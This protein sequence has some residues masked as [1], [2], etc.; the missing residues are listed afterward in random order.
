[1]MWLRNSLRLVSLGSDAKE[2][3]KLAWIA[4]PRL[5]WLERRVYPTASSELAGLVALQFGNVGT[6][7]AQVLVV[8]SL[9]EVQQVLA[10]E[11]TPG[12][13]DFRA[14]AVG[15]DGSI[16]FSGQPA[17]MS[18]GIYRL[19]TTPGSF[20]LI[21]SKPADELAVDGVGDVVAMRFG[22]NSKGQSDL[23]QVTIS[24]IAPGTGDLETV[25]YQDTGSGGAYQ[26]V[27]ADLQ[28]HVY[29]AGQPGSGSVDGIYQVGATPNSLT[30]IKAEHADRL[31]TDSQ[32]NL[33]SM[34]F[35]HD[36]SGHDIG[37]AVISQITPA[38]AAETVLYSD[39]TT[40]DFYE[41]LAVESNG[42]IVFSG[43]PGPGMTDGIYRLNATTG[44]LDLLSAKHADQVAITGNDIL[45]MRFGQAA[46]GASAGQT[47]Q[48]VEVGSATPIETVISHD[49]TATNGAQQHVAVGADGTLV[50]SGQPAPG[51]GTGIYERAPGSSTFQLVST[52]PA[53]GLAIDAQ[54]DILA[55]RFGHDSHGNPLGA[56]IS[57]IAP[58]G[59]DVETVVYQDN[60]GAY[61]ALAVDQH[62]NIYFAGRPSATGSV[63]GIYQVGKTPASATL[64]KA[65]HEDRLAIDSEGDILA[66]RFGHDS[67]G[68]NIGGATISQIAPA[69]GQ[70]TVLYNDSTLGDYYQDLAVG[71]NDRVLF[72]GQPGK[73]MTDGVYALNANLGAL[74]LLSAKHADQLAVDSEGDL[75]AMRFGHAAYG[76]SAGQAA[77]LAESAPQPPI[78]TVLLHDALPVSGTYQ[79]VAVGPDGRTVISG[80][81]APGFSPGIYRL[82]AA[83]SSLQ[84][85]SNQAANELAIDSAG[86]ILAMRFG[87]D[88]Y[89]HV[90][91]AS[92]TEYSA[93][94]GAA[95]VIYN[96]PSTADKY[97]DLAVDPHGN[98]YIAGQ[99]GTSAADGVYK[100]VAGSSPTLVASG[101]ADRLAIDSDGDL[102]AM[103]FAHDSYGNNIGGATI[104][105]IAPSGGTPTVIYNDPSNGQNIYNDMAVG[106]N[107]QVLFSGHPAA[108]TTDG[109]YALDAT[110]GE[111]D[112][113]LAAHTDRL[114]SLGAGVVAE[115]GY[116]LTAT[117]GVLSTP[118][119]LATFSDPR[120][121]SPLADYS[122]Q[123]SWGDQTSSAGALTF[124]A[125][126]GVFTVTGSHTYSAAT[127]TQITVVIGRLGSANTTVT[128]AANVAPLPSTA[129]SGPDVLGTRSGSVVQFGDQTPFETL[130]AREA[131]QGA[132]DFRAL[133]TGSDGTVVF[134]AKP[135]G[136]ADGIYRLGTTPGS[137]T[138]VSS[139]PADKLA[140]DSHGDIL[141]M[142][143]GHDAYGHVA[144]ATISSIAPGTGDIETVIYQNAAG[145][146]QDLAVDQHGN[147]YFAGQPGTSATDGIY[148]VGSTP[149]SASL[150]KAE[151]TDRLAI[152]SEGDLLAMRFGQNS[153]GNNIGGAAISQIAPASGAE[154]VIYNDATT[155]ERYYQ[156]LA[157]DTNGRVLFSDN[158]GEIYRLSPATGTLDLV[159]NTQA[160]QIAVDAKGD[161]LAMRTDLVSGVGQLIELGPQTSVEPVLLRGEGTSSPVVAVASNGSVVVSGISEPGTGAGIYRLS[162]NGSLQLVSKQ[163][164]DKLAID[165]EGDILAMRFGHDAYGNDVGAAV[166]SIAPGG[167]DV[168]TL[169]YQDYGG[170]Y[171]DMAVDQHGN[172]YLAGQPSATG[173]TDGVYELGT[174][175]N[176]LTLVKA[177]HADALA[178]DAEGD[179]LAMRFGHDAYGDH[180]GG[181]IVSEIAPAT[182]AQ[183]VLYNDPVN[184]YEGMMAGPN[185]QIMLVGSPGGANGLYRLN[186][187]A[188]TLDLLS[189]A[190]VQSAAVD[191]EGNILTASGY[192]GG[193]AEVDEIT[194]KAPLE[195]VLLPGST[196]G[197]QDAV[198]APDGSLIVSGQPPG[199]SSPGIYQ[200]GNTPGNPKLI[201]STPAD[202]LAVDSE[203]D[204]FAVRFA[205]DAYGQN[206]GSVSIAEYNAAS[207]AETI[208]YNDSSTADK[209]Q[210]LAVDQHGNVY[211]AGQ[212]GATAADGVYKLV[213]GS[214]PSLV[215]SGHADRLA[216]DSE[217][218]LLAMQFGH[219]AYGH[220][221]GGTI[222]QISPAGGTPSVIYNDTTLGDFYNDIAVDT[223][224]QTLLSGTPGPGMTDGVYT[225]NTTSGQLSLV[226]PFDTGQIAALPAA[227]AATGGATIN[228]NVGA[229]TGN[230]T[231]AT[232]TDPAGPGPLAIY[233]ADVSWGD[234]SQPTTA[235]ISFDA[236]SGTFTVQGSHT[237][238]VLGDLPV[239]V[240]VHRAGSADANVGD[241]VDVSLP[242][243]SAGTLAMTE[244]TAASSSLATFSDPISGNYTAVINWGD[245][246][247]S[248][249]SVSS[250]ADGTQTVVGSHAYSEEG[251][252]TVTVTLTDPDGNTAQTQDTAVVADATINATASAVGA[253]EGSTFSG[254]LAT[255]SDADPNGTVGD[256]TATINWGDGTS[257]A[258][259][260]TAAASGGFAVTGAHL[261]AEEAQNL[262]IS[263]VIADVGGARSTSTGTANVADASLH[264]SAATVSVTSSGQ[265][266]NLLIATFTDD[267]GPEPAANYH[268]AIDWGDGSTTTGSI[269]LV[270]GVFQVTG[271]HQYAVGSGTFQVDVSVQ[272][273][274]GSTDA[275][276]EQATVQLTAHQ[277]YVSGVYEDVLARPPDPPG[278]A[279]WTQQ[280]D[281]GSLFSSIAAEIGHSAEYYANFVIKPDY[282]R[283]LGRAADAAGLQFWTN[284]MLG[285][286]TDQ[287]LEAGFIAS[288]EFYA[289]AGNT[290]AAWVT[291][292]YKLLLGRAPDQTGANYWNAQLASLET[293]E[294]AI[295]ARSQIALRIAE[296]QENNTNLINDD[297]FH[298]LGRAA[299]P[300]GLQYWLQQF[301]NGETNEDVIAGFTGS[302]EYYKDKTGVSP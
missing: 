170:S 11:A 194:P 133:A 268:A 248:A 50:I 241:Q 19:G 13:G 190:A 43:Q 121:P 62:G 151:H 175:S 207:G 212:P 10:Q 120:G 16:V 41:G 21:S 126:T 193:A 208:V 92:I 32:G 146:Y 56:T 178:V 217:G 42:Q 202:E 12:S 266:A 58:G 180:T 287:Q 142:R 188:G 272:D 145:A 163:P 275:L 274:G 14:L 91:G 74:D 55:M 282:S 9:E 262:P 218:D 132:G 186:A 240:T 36:S 257:S 221:A 237:Y 150:I 159:G 128:S 231:L 229:T 226:S 54:D 134:S 116:I 192:A 158:S 20:Q 139:Q 108:G 103:R 48:L 291:A 271:S 27:A 3:R 122:A 256:Y 254:T 24:S 100:L 242:S 73:G 5:E 77:Q 200:L 236:T 277:L 179:I 46:Y 182:G 52:T 70:E 209:Y 112:L 172:I 23:S 104:S 106:A 251:T 31:A 171:Q 206:A 234:Q 35:G 84:V 140:I 155:G 205:H 174:K 203:G 117:P 136:M 173:S 53:D 300:Q 45:A 60:G 75:L 247:T 165:S 232:F 261:Y 264:L 302:P 184:Y 111:I 210:D 80:E 135:A 298:Y 1:M 177:G 143:L 109:V 279:F 61:Q 195:T 129:Q 228:A 49:A 152:D 30:L 29:V 123:I 246:A 7:V 181:A 127:Q 161:I 164:A 17:G 270:N 223:A 197:Y 213:P 28:G 124:D 156:G 292:V 82:G 97:Q 40:G 169:L 141:A 249:G 87:H 263:V 168:E 166:A 176:G 115:G 15:P 38:T 299:D 88:A 160:D 78:E 273:D 95:T 290:D 144:G 258:G 294:T 243:S 65:E 296:S 267:G 278:L 162:S 196:S 204:I 96:D 198:A 239:T 222:S 244:G 94:S 201:S 39:T 301:A 57:S 227:I 26:D 137:F 66:M 90:G 37:G 187:A 79:D 250:S 265:A 8:P 260:V 276:T 191:A 286:L 130:L 280:L 157:V 64:I 216:V 183:T 230:Q 22:T 18:D 59:G 189:T 98:V 105:E 285:G 119:T 253:T 68:H 34:H 86:D 295:Q 211:L 238:T 283:L 99:P 167:G 153:Y 51:L 214:S 148:Q 138:L 118:Q 149:S 289:T 6:N 235:T 293:T 185:D 125:T 215:A 71:P 252:A 281:A 102:L 67:Y 219:D 284:Q 297:Y 69:S 147:V 93:T 255:F 114:A 33:L 269:T 233:S 154:T 288:A 259:T 81:P 131:T 224:G 107:G 44:T 85:V 113:V 89:G 110:T 101:H 25:L 63:D 199:A 220:D 225:L 245:G 83:P 2:Q 4:K 76:A 72:A 47:A